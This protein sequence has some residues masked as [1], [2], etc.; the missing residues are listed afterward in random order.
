MNAAMNPAMVTRIVSSIP[1][2]T[3]RSLSGTA[4]NLDGARA[5]SDPARLAGMV[6]LLQ[7]LSPLTPLSQDEQRALG[8][9]GAATRPSLA[10]DD[11]DEPGHEASSMEES[12][13]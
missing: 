8:L 3:A 5:C 1:E 4:F 13:L 2:R 11:V 6:R 7:W 10:E 12:L 9:H